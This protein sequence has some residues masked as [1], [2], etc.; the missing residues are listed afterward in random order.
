[1]DE[2]IS[3]EENY[4]FLNFLK[5]VE[6]TSSLANV[7]RDGRNEGRE[8]EE[9]YIKVRKSKESATFRKSFAMIKRTTI[10]MIKPWKFASSISA[11]AHK[12]VL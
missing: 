12:L 9:K 1:M 6:T 8:L 4:N 10:V 11:Y 7:K 5:I 3:Y 2:H